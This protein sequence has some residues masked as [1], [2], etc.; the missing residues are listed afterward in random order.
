M[1]KDANF[2]L[3]LGT[4][5]IPAG[6]IPPSIESVK[7]IFVDSL[8][9][10][11]IDFGQIEVYATPRRTAVLVSKLAESQREEEVEL[12]GPSVKAAYDA[13]G[14]PTKALEGFMK[15]NGVAPADVFTRESDKGSYVFAK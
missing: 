13:S 8:G 6:Y 7:K 5:E 14:K 4:E 3:E 15:G 12:K 11:R 1:L 2:L 10:N 9:G